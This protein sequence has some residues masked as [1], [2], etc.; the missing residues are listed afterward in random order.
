MHSNQSFQGNF[1]FDSDWGASRELIYTALTR[2]KETITIVTDDISKIYAVIKN[3]PIREIKS[4]FQEI[5]ES[6]FDIELESSSE[7]SDG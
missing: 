2:A 7:F 6:M 4:G 5:F 3:K 1:I